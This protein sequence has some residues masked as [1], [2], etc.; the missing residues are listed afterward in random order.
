[1]MKEILNSSPLAQ[2]K[3]PFHVPLRRNNVELDILAN[4][5]FL[6]NNL[7]MD[8]CADT[9][10]QLATIAASSNMDRDTS[11]QKSNGTLSAAYNQAG[12]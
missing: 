8:A 9:D 1:M 3:S 10:K 7:V 6:K 4:P 12:I 5:N 2:L 11:A